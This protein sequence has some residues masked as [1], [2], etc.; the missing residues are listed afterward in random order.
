MWTFVRVA[1]RNIRRNRS[2][3][4][5]TLT[6]IGFGVLMTIFLLGFSFG[7]T[8]M[9]TDDS[10]KSKVGALQ[11]HR[12]GYFDVKDSSPLDYDMEQGGELERKIRSVRGVEEV[13]PRLV[14]Q[15]IVN[16]PGASSMI[17]ATGADPVREY[18]VLPW[19]QGDI[20]GSTVRADK[21]N[22]AVIGLDMADA[23][24]FVNHEQKNINGKIVDSPSPKSDATAVISAARKSGQQNAE[25]VEVIGLINSGNAFETK[26]VGFV[27]LAF[28]QDLLDMKGRV[29]EYL[30]S[31]PRREDIPRVRADLLATLGD[32]YEIQDWRDVRPNVA[33]VITVQRVILSSIC[34]VFLIIAVIGVVNTMLMSVMERTR[35]IGTMMAVGVTRGQVSL[36][37]LLEGMVLALIGG[38]VGALGGVG[39]DKAIAAIGGLPITVPGSSALRHVLPSPEPSLVVIA[40]GAAVLGAL[41]ASVYPAWR[42]SRLRP[43]EALRAV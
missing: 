37:F 9:I 26:R 36:L 35:E 24:T 41:G 17:F 30:V 28:A 6:A 5:L 40:I 16:G 7:F 15:A 43:V 11:V 2:R 19:A 18:R 1:V 38:A 22:G 39:I 21:A 32:G 13:A 27:P 29:N 14:F 3:T 33:D 42:A 8:N 25:D 34:F 4:V 31:V 12:K 23:L 10:I 20:A